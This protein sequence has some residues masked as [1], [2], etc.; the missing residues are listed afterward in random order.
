VG[1]R[2]PHCYPGTDIY[3]A[4]GKWARLAKLKRK[5]VSRTI[6]PPVLGIEPTHRLTTYEGDG[7]ECLATLAPEHLL[8]DSADRRR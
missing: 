2:L 1:R 6:V 8:D 5:H 3:V 7:D 4:D